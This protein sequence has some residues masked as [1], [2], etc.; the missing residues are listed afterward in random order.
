MLVKVISPRR[1]PPPWRADERDECFI[2][3]DANGLPLAYVYYDDEPGRRSAE[4][5]LLNRDEARRI[6]ANI[7]KLPSLLRSARSGEGMMA[8]AEERNE[9]A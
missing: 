9:V 7:A 6:A 4:S 3:R 2:V 8:A 1:L 5:K